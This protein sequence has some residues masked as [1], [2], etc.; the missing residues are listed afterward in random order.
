MPRWLKVVLIVFGSIALLCLISSVVA[1]SW[2]NE[3]KEKLKGVSERAKNEGAAF[4]YQHDADECVN[5]ALRRLEN[6]RGIIEQAQN[7]IFLKACLEKAERAPQFCLGV[8]PRSEILESARWAVDRCVDK[9]KTGDQ[10]CARLMQAVQE[11]CQSKLTT[12]PA[13]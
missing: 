7:K 4:A 13:G 11:A 9:G 3:N 6:H 12:I 10:D 2:F 1:Y 5:E 8:P